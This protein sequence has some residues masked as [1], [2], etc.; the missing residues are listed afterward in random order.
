[1]GKAPDPA[2]QLVVAQKM[3]ELLPKIRFQP[4]LSAIVQAQPKATKI[5]EG[6]E[7]EKSW[8]CLHFM[9]SGKVSAIGNEPIEKLIFGG[10]EISDTENVMGYGPVRYFEADEVAEIGAALESYP[11]EQKASKFDSAAAAEA[12]IYCP[13]HSLEELIH[14]FN[15]VKKYY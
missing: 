3:M 6:L 13:D 11:I 10:A 4:D 14:Y 2:D 9:L 1:E 5:P 7:I 8:H 15:L 12:N